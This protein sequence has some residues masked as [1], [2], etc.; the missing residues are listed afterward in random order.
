M[1]L[2]RLSLSA[3]KMTRYGQSPYPS[4]GNL[5]WRRD[6][7]LDSMNRGEAYP[8]TCLLRLIRPA[9]LSQA[10]ELVANL[11]P[12]ASPLDSS[13]C[14]IERSAHPYVDI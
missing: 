2:L 4:I 13:S 10:E 12:H 5:G 7:V 8:P 11:A 3:V 1:F 14:S 9:T 6:P